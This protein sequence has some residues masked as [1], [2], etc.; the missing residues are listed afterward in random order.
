MKNWI[1][2]FPPDEALC[3][4]LDVDQEA[5]ELAGAWFNMRLDAPMQHRS[6]MTVHVDDDGFDSTEEAV[7]ARLLTLRNSL[8][9][10]LDQIEALTSG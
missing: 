4:E 10:C 6:M 9:Y 1:S 3:F 8:D 2:I 7:K 5:G